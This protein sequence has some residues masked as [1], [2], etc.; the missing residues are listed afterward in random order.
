MGMH[1]EINDE[2]L[3]A[4]KR[5]GVIR[6]RQVVDREWVNRMS[7]VVDTL[8]DQPSQWANDASPGAKS[9]RM[10]TDRYQ[11]RE[12]P[13]IRAYL[14]ESGVARLV[15]QAM[16]SSVARFYFDHILVKEPQTTTATPW[17]QDAPY[18]PFRGKQICSIWLALTDVTVE[19]S[20][21]EFVR[22][23]HALGKYYLPEIFGDRENHPNEWAR[24]A[25]GEPVPPIEDNRQDYDIV[26]W[27]ME[28][29]DAVIFSAYTLHG[30][31]GNSSQS[32]RRAAISTRWLGDDAIWHPHPGADPTVTQDDVSLAPGELAHDDEVFP[33][34]WPRSEQPS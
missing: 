6:L 17:H 8:L 28:A 22:G 14:Y 7:N 15:A 2:E 20:A 18:W 4:Y 12:N 33:V 34:V 19:Q 24:A 13:E 5:D 31:P 10:F 23:S 30:A 21:M 9:N 32:Q 25:E 26:G 29:G 16:Q 11:W 27:D 1:R 3:A